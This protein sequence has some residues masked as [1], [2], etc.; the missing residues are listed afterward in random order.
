MV[1][2]NVAYIGTSNWS[3]DYFTDTA[4]IG[5]VLQ[6]T[7]EINRNETMQSIR[8]DLAN[9]FDRDWNSEYAHDMKRWNEFITDETY[10]T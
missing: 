9:I 7:S 10:S 5:L 8:K 4:G 1:T 6:E 3:A 2:D